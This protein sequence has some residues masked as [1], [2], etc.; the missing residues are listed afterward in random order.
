[1]T[2]SEATFNWQ[3]FEAAPVVGILR[4][5]S[6]DRAVQAAKAALAG[7]LT[8][9]EVTMNSDEPGKVL[10]ALAEAGGNDVN[11]GAGTV[12]DVARLDAALAGGA[13]F[14]VTPT[15]TEAVIA[16]CVA[17]GVP[18]FV[19]ALTPTEVHRA[20]SLGAAMVKVFPASRLGP[21]YL[22]DLK[23]PLDQ[24]KLL[25]T[26]GIS[27]ET[28]QAYQVAGAD[29]FG[30]G[31]PLFDRTRVEAGDFAWVRE[32]AARFRQAAGK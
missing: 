31:S 5:F 22:K 2:V 20:W 12:T 7:G 23:G 27:L 16:Q 8:T 18:I 6:A 1:M 19:G 3:A 17:K 30:V 28:I 14:I 15:V 21:G 13:S 4:G 26:G 9:I 25:P 10:A 11:V 29:G 24:V 32:Q